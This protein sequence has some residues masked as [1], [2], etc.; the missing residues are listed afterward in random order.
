MISSILE[1]RMTFRQKT[2][3]RYLNNRG[4]FWIKPIGNE[5]KILGWKYP[6]NPHLQCH[7]LQCANA[8]SLFLLSLGA[9][10]ARVGHAHACIHAYMPSF[11]QEATFLYRERTFININCNYSQRSL[12]YFSLQSQLVW[13]EK[14]QREN[15]IS[16]NVY[17]EWLKNR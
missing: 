7:E 14:K 17:R 11:S 1:N 2:C 3:M 6:H 10:P 9:R 5:N 8:R 15:S 4:D 12:T 13:I 16:I